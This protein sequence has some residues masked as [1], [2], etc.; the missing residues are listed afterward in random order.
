MPDYARLV[1]ALEVIP[2]ICQRDGCSGDVE[3]W[4]PLCEGFFCAEHDPLPDGHQ[5]RV[6]DNLSRPCV[7]ERYTSASSERG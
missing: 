7:A 2:Y 1:E 5:C 4:C 6:T 3:T